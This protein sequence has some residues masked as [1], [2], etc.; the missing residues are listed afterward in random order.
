MWVCDWYVSQTNPHWDNWAFGKWNLLSIEPTPIL[1]WEVCPISKDGLPIY[2][3]SLE[4]D[5][6]WSW[7]R[8]PGTNGGFPIP[9]RIGWENV[10]PC[11]LKYETTVVLSVEIITQEWW[12]YFMT[13]FSAKRMIIISRI[14]IW[15]WNW[16]SDQRLWKDSLISSRWAPH[17][18]W[19][20]SMKRNILG[21]GGWMDAPRTKRL[22]SIH[23]FK[24]YRIVGS[25]DR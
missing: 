6:L 15:S 23:H 12:M 22:V 11:L 2:W 18:K 9:L 25:P 21:S 10:S 13:F 19:L 24:W 4:Y 14:L 5:E 1:F 3:I 8:V 7:Y 17:L 20:A 16:S